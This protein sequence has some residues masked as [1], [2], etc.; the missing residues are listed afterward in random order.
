MILEAKTKDLLR[1]ELLVRQKKNKAY[2]LR[3][4]A[5]S[6]GVSPS[7]LSLVFNGGRR[8][9]TAKAQS[10]SRKLTWAANKKKYFATLAEYETSSS[11]KDQ[12]ALLPELEKY[13]TLSKQLPSL[14]LDSF[15]LISEWYHTAILAILTL[16]K[17]LKT[18]E[19]IAKRLNIP[20]AQCDLGLKRLQRLGLVSVDENGRWVAT[21]Q[22]LNLESVPSQA[23]RN[24]HKEVL[25]KAMVAIDDQ[26]FT[27]RDFSNWILTV[28]P[29]MLPQAKKKI[30]D[31]QKEML[32]FMEGSNPSN[33][34]QFSI[35]LFRVDHEEKGETKK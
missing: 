18:T 20:I 16:P 10:I 25:R 31:F 17:Y 24:Y 9:T 4:F 8:L 26:N 6:L 13:R 27:D 30:Q 35:Q 2:S 33:I 7:Y 32:Q 29:K 34:Y 5:Q 14:E 11:T 3:S 22:Q 19:K 15:S 21:H 23:I 12:F 28:D 1:D